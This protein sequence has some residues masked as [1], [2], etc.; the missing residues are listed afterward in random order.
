[1]STRE[2]GDKQAYAQFID[3]V[4]RE[5]ALGAWLFS[6]PSLAYFST[7]FDADSI[8]MYGVASQLSTV[9]KWRERIVE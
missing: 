2:I 8:N 3:E 7:Q 9:E 6:M 1:M 4:E 5:M